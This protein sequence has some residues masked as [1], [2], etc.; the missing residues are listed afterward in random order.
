MAKEDARDDSMDVA[1]ASATVVDGFGRDCGDEDDVANGAGRL[2]VDDDD[3]LIGAKASDW[4]MPKTNDS[5][6]KGNDASD[7]AAD[8]VSMVMM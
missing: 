7:A 5:D 8:G 4:W 3:D 6:S 2:K 1:V